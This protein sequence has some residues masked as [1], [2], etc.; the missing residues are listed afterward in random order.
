MDAAWVSIIPDEM[1]RRV[2]APHNSVCF[3]PEVPCKTKRVAIERRCPL[4]VLDV[5][6]RSTLDKLCRIGGWKC[7]HYAL[8]CCC[9]NLVQ[10]AAASPC[11]LTPALSRSAVML[12]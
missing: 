9:R 7:R 4:D 2:V 1:N 6:H 3:V 8:L 12:S 10:R 11:C 5:K